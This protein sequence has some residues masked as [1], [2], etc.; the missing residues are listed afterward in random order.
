MGW[1]VLLVVLLVALAVLAAKLKAQSHGGGYPYKK[2]QTLFS[3]AERSFLGVLE[4]AVGGEYRI[5]G[6]VR[7]A[8][9][10]SVNGMSDRGAWQRAFNRISAKHFDFV[11]CAKDDLEILAAIELDDKSHQQRKRQAR[12]T[13]LVGLCQAISLPLVQVPAQR[14]YSV[15]D[16][17]AQV[18][19]ALG[20]RQEPVLEPPV[21]AA[22]VAEVPPVQDE[23][24]TPAEPLRTAQTSA[25]TEEPACPR[26]SAPMVRRRAKA[27]TRA[28]QEFWGCSTFPKCRTIIPVPALTDAPV[29][30]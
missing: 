8:D 29:D 17:R 24:A 3:P 27:G 18:L 1:F 2:N 13:F 15:Q 12:D 26:C 28:G 4:Q 23:Q 20:V 9:V 14:A 25:P 7:V 21:D 16:L 10:V 6:K 11:L 30:G 22:S 19:S 5:F